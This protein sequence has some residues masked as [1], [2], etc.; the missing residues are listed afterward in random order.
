MRTILVV[1]SLAPGVAFAQA[2]FV[3][4]AVESGLPGSMGGELNGIGGNVAVLDADGD[5]RLD[6][7]IADG[8]SAGVRL[9]RN[10]GAP[11]APAFEEATD[12][13]G[14]GALA[15]T[16]IGIGV[17][18][19]DR[20]GDVD[21]YLS[22]VGQDR[23]LLGD[24][25]GAFT[26]VT[27][28]ALD[29]RWGFQS[30]VALGDLEGD[31]DLDIAVGAYLEAVQWPFHEGGRNRLL[32][33][34]GDG[35][36]VDRAPEWGVDDDA[37]TLAV[38]WSDLDGDGD[39]DLIEANDFG[40]LLRPS[41]AWRNDGPGEAGWTLTDVGAAWG[42][43][44]RLY[45]MGLA[46]LDAD[47][48][49][50]LDVY[51]TSIGRA[52][53]I[54]GP[55][56]GAPEELTDA[57]GVGAAW[58]S[59]GYRVGW[60]PEVLDVDGDGIEDLWVRTG[61]MAAT[62]FLGNQQEQADVVWRLDG[63]GGAERMDP[64]LLPQAGS[65]GRGIVAADIDGDGR[66]DL[67]AGS[68]DDGPVH[69]WMGGGPVTTAHVVLHA[70]V[71]APGAPGA[72]LVLGCGAGE[73]VRELAAGGAFGSA[74]PPGELW[75]GIPDGCDAPTLSVRWPSGVWTPV[76]PVARGER[77]EVEEPEWWSVELGEVATV[78]VRPLDA[79]GEPVGPG[80]AL[81]VEVGGAKIPTAKVEDG[82]WQ[83]TVPRPLEGEVHAT[84][85]LDGV[86][87]PAHPAIPAMELE[88][89]QVR[90]WPAHLVER[91]AAVLTVLAQGAVSLEVEGASVE[92]GVEGGPGWAR[93]VVTP[94]AGGQSLTVT[95]IVEGQPGEPVVLPVGRILD[96]EASRLV[97]DSPWF[98]AG[99]GASVEVRARD[100]NRRPSS[101]GPIEVRV[102]GA[103]VAS[104][105]TDSLLPTTKVPIPL[106]AMADGAVLDVTVDG[107]SLGEATLH[108]WA[109]VDQLAAAV[110]GE[111][112]GMGL[113]F[114]GC[115]DD[116]ADEVAVVVLPRGADGHPL[117]RGPLAGLLALSSGGADQDGGL[118]SV[119]THL[120][121]RVRCASTPGE[122]PVTLTPG[123]AEAPLTVRAA[124]PGAPD[125]AR[126]EL[127]VDGGVG[128]PGAQLYLLVTPRNAA[129]DLMG[130][131]LAVGVRI[132]DGAGCAPAPYCGGG[133]YCAVAWV[134]GGDDGVM[135]LDAVVQGEPSG[136]PLALS[137]DG[138]PVDVPL[139]P[140]P[141]C[142]PPPEPPGGEDT[143]MVQ[144]DAGSGGADAGPTADSPE[145]GG[146]ETW[147]GGDADASAGGDTPGEM[148]SKGDAAG[149]I[150]AASSG[151]GGGCG[152]AGGAAG[153][154][155]L[156][157]LAWL[158]RALHRRRDDS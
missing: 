87:L 103:Q 114:E 74:R 4:R 47:G 140:D 14:L 135:T 20:D 60:A 83:A 25:H 41:R 129:G 43:D 96:A 44:R 122:W 70:T 136:S 149:E 45:G 143:G 28:R 80:H 91:R 67:L 50:A 156:W 133:R 105:V 18:D 71:S 16:V 84:L 17:G 110:D 126:T 76:G 123:A 146:G 26:D 75:L 145:R 128:G 59:S 6:V 55:G 23:L 130:S 49:G 82:W 42:L 46:V 95:P 157:V 154:W 155:A 68:A 144:P 88:G 101:E 116:G 78:R 19:L 113:A 36:L 31:G 85:R 7:L 34:D 13:A 58:A 124:A 115:N 73:R 51:M 21:L 111:R 72:R 104:G 108:A 56:T 102:G 100:A 65:A 153:G 39:P 37:T 137:V 77:V 98:Q 52:A 112:T 61:R 148:N 33:R 118:V 35:R 54:G 141:L 134:T 10:V 93:A 12:A 97:V 69:L 117:P 119:G 79:G 99:E 94:L 53:L 147:S 9:F 127:E 151:S 158:A 5:G 139:T 131:G 40:P 120:E 48:D 15:V 29:G 1:A 66:V 142:G 30:G 2:P 8:Q 86:A 11:G 125:P 138:E 22:A 38:A 107:V 106:G 63:V 24:G 132:E 109:T 152:A 90:A 32:V 92:G 3:D 64:E 121:G 81:S 150:A 57:M 89:V 27:E 62:W